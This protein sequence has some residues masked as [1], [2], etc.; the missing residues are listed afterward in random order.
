MTGADCILYAFKQEGVEAIFGYPG[1]T[2]IDIFDK[3]YESDIP[4]YL[5]R[6]EQAAVHAADGYARAKGKVGVCIATSGPGATNLTTGLATAYMDSIPLVAITGQIASQLIGNDAFQEADVCGITRSITKHNYLVKNIDDLPRIL[7]SAFMIARTG[8]PGPVVIDIP[9]DIQQAETHEPYPEELSIRGYNPTIDGNIQ[10]IK[11]AADLI[12]RSKRPLI[13][14]GGGV[15]SSG[16][17]NELFELATRIQAPVTT[18]LMGLGTF[19]EDHPLALKMLGMHGTAYANYAVQQADLIIAV[20]VRFDDRVT[21]KLSQFAPEADIIH[22]DIDPTSIRKNLQV[23]IPVVG[24]V[25]KVLATLLQRVGKLDNPGWSQHV[26]DLKQEHP[27]EYGENGHIQPQWVIEELGKMTDD[28]TIIATDV[29][30]HQ[31][32]TALFYGFRT[33]RTLITSGGL[34]TMGYGFPAALG[35]QSAY[36]DRQVVLVS[37]D[38]S[39]Q[40]NLQELATAVQYRLPVKVII[41][42]NYSLGMV[43]QWQSMFYHRRFSST[44]LRKTVECPPQCNHNETHCPQPV[45]DFIKLAEAYGAVGYHTS[46]PKEIKPVLEKT[47]NTAGPVLCVFEIDKEEHVYPMVPSGAAIDQMIRGM[48]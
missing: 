24:D 31:M 38:G 39:F 33:P 4:V 34:G 18:S 42:Q 30:Q 44:C 3:L 2:V 32:W 36:P 48:A 22:I 41:M 15:V 21:G 40:M 25:K 47:L 11:K 19:P 5:P 28:D 43:R 35:A 23:T 29:G 10:Q 26:A 1:G 20:G 16:G 17:H 6:H 9:K 12:Q 14:A 7:K 13:F 8:R 37:G 46:I 27:L 45:P